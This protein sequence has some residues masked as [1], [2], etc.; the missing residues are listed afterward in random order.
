MMLSVVCP[1]THGAGPKVCCGLHAVFLNYVRNGNILHCSSSSSVQSTLMCSTPPHCKLAVLLLKSMAHGCLQRSGRG[2]AQAQSWGTAVSKTCCT[3]TCKINIESPV[4]SVGPGCCCPATLFP[5]SPALSAQNKRPPA[6]TPHAKT[7]GQCPKSLIAASSIQ[8]KFI[9][10]PGRD[11][12]SS[13]YKKK[14]KTKN[15]GPQR[16]QSPK[17]PSRWLDGNITVRATLR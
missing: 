2:S 5:T 17:K 14:Y 16:P 12:T 7:F 13:N 11:S 8:G 1:R 10:A 4:L 15:G 9:N 3:S 6:H